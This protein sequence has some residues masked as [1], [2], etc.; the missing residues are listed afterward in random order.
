MHRYGH[1]I[2]SVEPTQTALSLSWEVSHKQIPEAFK[3]AVYRGVKAQFQSGGRLSKYNTNG[4]LIRIVDGSS[5]DTDSNEGSFEIAA[6]FALL[7]ALEPMAG[8]TT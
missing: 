8:R 4:L 6:S 2:L 7:S 1:V 3:A 5:H